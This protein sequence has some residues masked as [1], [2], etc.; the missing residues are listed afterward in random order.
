MSAK[1]HVHS[2]EEK[3][4]LKVRVRKIAGQLKAIET[5][6]DDDRDCPE[7][8]NQVV[9]ARKGLKSFAEKLIHEHLHHCIDGAQQDQGKKKLR[10]LLDVLERYVE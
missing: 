8:L 4:A 7:I 3:H 10:E 6:L 1:E 9:S 2:A 5:M